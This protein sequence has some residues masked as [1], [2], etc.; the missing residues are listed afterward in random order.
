MKMCLYCDTNKTIICC[1][2][3]SQEEKIMRSNEEIRQV[4]PLKEILDNV[5]RECILHALKVT[6]GN[7]SRASQLLEISRTALIYKLKRYKDE[8]KWMDGN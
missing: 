3:S 6:N 2:C 8:D 1:L 7:Q 5:E 4:L